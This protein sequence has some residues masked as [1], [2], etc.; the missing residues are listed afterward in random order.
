MLGGNWYK[1]YMMSEI[2]SPAI[3][4][5]SLHWAKIMSGGHQYRYVCT[6]DIV[7]VDTLNSE[8]VLY[9]AIQPSQIDFNLNINP[10]IYPQFICVHIWKILFIVHLRNSI[11]GKYIIRKF[12]KL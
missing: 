11:V 1:G 7:G 2:I 9:S 6:P 12:L 5:N 8:H 4:W 3:Q 10:F